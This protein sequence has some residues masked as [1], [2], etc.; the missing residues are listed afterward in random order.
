MP[1]GVAMIGTGGIALANHVPGIQLCPQAEL[2]ALCDSN[3]SILEKAGQATG[4]NRTYTD[5]KLLIEQPGVDAVIIATPNVAHFPIAMAAI[6]AGKHVMCEKPLAMNVGEAKEMYQAAEKAGVR[7]MTAFTYRFVPA[8]RYMRHLVTFG[9]IGQVYHFRANRFLDWGNRYI[10]WRQVKALAG[11]GDLGDMLSHRIDYGVSMLGPIARLVSRL[12]RFRDERV[13]DQG[14]LHPSDLDDWAAIL[15]E[16]QQGATAFLESSKLMTGRGEDKRSQDYCEVNG[17]EGS[18]VYY[19]NRPTELQVG[20]PG[21]DGL[22]TLTIPEEFLKVPG[23][24]RNARDGDPLQVFRFDQD[25]EFIEAI[26]NQR[27]CQPSF[28]DGM[29]VQAIMDAALLSEAEQRWVEVAY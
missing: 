23:S 1:V 17:F 2:V 9:A 6:A 18:L 10:G 15:G 13:D 5:Y 27:P 8:M 4:I 7:H 19:L 22:E 11:S 25:F 26:L 14:N 24:P 20:K 29:V 12:K 16:F 3:E 28:Y 21:G